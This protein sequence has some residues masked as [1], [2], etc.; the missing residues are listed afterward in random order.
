MGRGPN[1][2]HYRTLHEDFVQGTLTCLNQPTIMKVVNNKFPNILNIEPTNRCNLRCVYCPRMKAK[3]G[4]GD[5]SWELYTKIINEA[6][7]YDPLI[8]LNFHKD[9]ES[10]LHPRFLDMIR[11]AK[12]KKVAKTIHLNTNALCWNKETIEEILDSG[13]DDI[14]VSIDAARSETYSKHKGFNRLGE[15]ENNVKLFLKIRNQRGLDKPFLRV[16]MMEFD[17]IQPGEI[18]EFY[19]KWE[20]IADLVQITGVHNWSGAIPDLKVTDES[21]DVRYPCLI[22]WYSLVVCWNGEVTV[23]SVDWDTEINVG[24][25][26]S[27]SLHE[28]WNGSKIKDARRSQIE[29]KYHKYDVCKDCVVWVSIGD[30][31]DWLKKEKTFYEEKES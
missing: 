26:N 13:L 16:K 4:I 1:P 19:N 25:A 8:M 27:Q 9:G 6:A 29:K 17:E 31:T 30:L 24:D 15:V 20:N 2:D 22:M 12:E 21:S 18:E 10:F 11:Y 23:C 28:I 14:T 7:R 5:M 3:K